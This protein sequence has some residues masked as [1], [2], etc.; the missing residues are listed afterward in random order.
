MAD[1][2]RYGYP[3]EAWECAKAEAK[4]FLVSCARRRTTT[5]YAELCEVV[6]SAR[7]RPYSFAMM[8]FLNEVCT[9]EDAI[10]GVMLASLVCRKDSGMPGAGYF[11][12][13]TRLGRDTRDERAY[14]RSEVERIYAAF[15]AEG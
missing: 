2:M 13:A 3:K 10:H 1:D 14:W 12:H 15:P 7:L 6:T 8:A 4:E 9:E 5:T 11:R